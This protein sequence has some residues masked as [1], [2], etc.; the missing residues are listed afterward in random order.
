M[1]KTEERLPSTRVSSQGLT[2]RALLLA[3]G[4]TVLCGVWIRQAEIVVIA[5][6]IT[7]SVPAIPAL[8]ALFLLLLLNQ[9]LRLAKSKAEFSRVEMLTVYTFVAIGSGMAGV[10]VV[11]FWI[12][13]ITAL[14]WYQP[15]SPDFGYL[16]QFLPNWVVPHN[17][18]LLMGLYMGGGPVPWKVWMIPLLAWTGF[19]V[20]AW[21]AM[22]C[23]LVMLRKRWTQEERLSFPVVELALEMTDSGDTR[24]AR[25][26][27]LNPIMWVG[28]GLTAAFNLLNILHALRPAVPGIAWNVALGPA[29]ASLP[30]T[31]VVPI[32]VVFQPLMIGFG[33]LVSTEISFSIW[34]FFL[35]TK[36]EALVAGSMG[37][38]TAGIP[39]PSE[40]GMGAF[41]VLGLGLLYSSRHAF[42]RGFVE[43]FTRSRGDRDEHAPFGLKWAVL[44]LLVASGLLLVFCI[45]LGMAAWVAVTYLTLLGLVA[46]VCARIRAEAGIPS[47]WAFPSGISST[48]F[49][50]TLGSATFMGAGPGT[51]AAL[52]LLV[53]VSRG[54]FLSLAG[55]YQV[56]SLRIAEKTRMKASHMALVVVLACVVG[57]GVAYYFHFTPYYSSGAVHMRNGD[58]WGTWVAWSEFGKVAQGTHTAIPP[59]T[60]RIAA[61]GVGIALTGLLIWL[62]ALG[63]CPVHPLGFAVGMASGDGLWFSFFLVW[64]LKTVILRYG[65]IRLYRTAIPGFLG[66]ALGHLFTA[67]VVWG[68]L[69]AFYPDLV[70]GYSVWFG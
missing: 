2:W 16:Q 51:L 5:T 61:T 15:D 49:L 25:P 8:A 60:G 52:A 68:I 12:A 64:I 50:Y 35:I 67:G 37:F 10:G 55:G 59:D 27:F 57:L 30:W 28:F 44:G 39:Y 14:W 70:S 13:T 47:L 9:L 1:P 56:D 3:V 20:T 62:R 19:F 22:L 45:A 36:L 40:Q 29:K 43:L 24:A 53:L 23:L 69:G 17:Y 48:I 42:K 26:F 18:D 34:F 7:E 66:F 58:I 65:G 4:L 46:L 31:T 21:C 41:I 33:F 63:G 32:N 54:F 11:R 6:Q 38:A